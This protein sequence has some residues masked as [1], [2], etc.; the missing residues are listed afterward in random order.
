M[1]TGQGK[2]FPVKLNGRKLQGVR[3]EENI[4]GETHGIRIYV[5][6]GI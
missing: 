3:T 2:D 4:P 5:I 1:Q 6:T